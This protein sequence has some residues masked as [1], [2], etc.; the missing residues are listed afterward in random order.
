[1]KSEKYRQFI[2][3][4]INGCVAV[5]IQY[6][7]YLLLINVMNE[8]AANTIAYFVSFC[9]NFIVTSY[10]TFNSKP[11]LKKL[12]GFG[13]SHI[14]NYFLQQAFLALYLN[15]GVSKEFAA[16]L[17]MGSALPINFTILHFVYKKK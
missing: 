1:M 9:Y 6:A 3:F 10:W 14:L 12:G 13:S 17:A 5:A 2:R 11:S 7:I 16:I 4:C 15:I 8:F